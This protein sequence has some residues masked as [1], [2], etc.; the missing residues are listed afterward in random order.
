MASDVVYDAIKAY[1]VGEGSTPAAFNSAPLQWENEPAIDTTD[2]DTRGDPDNP[3][4][5][6][7][8]VLVEMTGTLYGQQSIGANTQAANRWDEEGQLWLHVFVPTGSGGHT[9]RHLAKTL[10]DVFRGAL[11]LNDNLEFMDAQIGMGEP[12]DEDG[13]WFR[14]SVSLNWRRMEA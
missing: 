14:V 5:P 13:T 12:G 3:A 4:K 1:L 9:A 10:A 2:P 11:L 7:P 6:A 8:W